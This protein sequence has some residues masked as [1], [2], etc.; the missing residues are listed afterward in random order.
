M[1]DEHCYS[2]KVVGQIHRSCLMHHTP[3]QARST[4]LFISITQTDVV[5]Q[6]RVSITT[7][8]SAQAKNLSNR[9]LMTVTQVLDNILMV[10]SGWLP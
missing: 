5:A 8:L 1:L 7:H 9:Y 6:A 10:D 2:A 4:F 3:F